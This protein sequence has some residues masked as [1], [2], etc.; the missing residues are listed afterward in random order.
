MMSF[1]LI[2]GMNKNYIY[3]QVCLF[4][5]KINFIEKII[6]MILLKKQKKIKE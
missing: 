5:E 1:F 2:K 3:K 6:D 4:F